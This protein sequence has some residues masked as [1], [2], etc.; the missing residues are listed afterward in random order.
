MALITLL[1]TRVIKHA[2]HMQC[3]HN[4]AFILIGTQEQ[5]K[6]PCS[7]TH[8]PGIYNRLYHNQKDHPHTHTHTHTHTHIH[9]PHTYSARTIRNI[10]PNDSLSFKISWMSGFTGSPAVR[11]S[12]SCFFTRRRRSAAMG[13]RSSFS[14]AAFSS[15]SEEP[16]SEMARSSRSAYYLLVF[17][18][19][20]WFL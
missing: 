20:N 18:Y 2:F 13:S 6:K 8:A 14:S 1:P 17:S 10:A 5:E 12:W 11:R 9:T 16:A 3:T 19:E 7:C 4:N 15:S